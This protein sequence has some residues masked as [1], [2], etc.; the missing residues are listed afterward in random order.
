MSQKLPKTY[1]PCISKDLKSLISH[2]QKV[3]HE[4][5]SNWIFQL[6][7]QVPQRWPTEQNGKCRMKLIDPISMD[8]ARTGPAEDQLEVG[9]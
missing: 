8:G 1:Y 7:T 5:P 9:L 6:G 3:G 2:V 4:V